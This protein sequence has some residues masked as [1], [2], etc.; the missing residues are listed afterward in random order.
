LGDGSSVTPAIPAAVMRSLVAPSTWPSFTSIP[1]DDATVLRISSAGRPRIPASACT[2]G[3]SR[4][5]TVGMPATSLWSA[6]PASGAPCR[7]VI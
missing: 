4:R 5:S 6:F 3:L 1:F 2:A 7:S